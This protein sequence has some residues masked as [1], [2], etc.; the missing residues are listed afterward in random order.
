MRSLLG[1][2]VELS[3]KISVKK[4]QFRLRNFK[5]SFIFV[6]DLQKSSKS[7]AARCAAVQAK[8]NPL[9]NTHAKQSFKCRK[10][11]VKTPPITEHLAKYSLKSTLLLSKEAPKSQNLVTPA[12]PT[13]LTPTPNPARDSH[14]SPALAHQ[15]L[16]IDSGTPRKFA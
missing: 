14:R 13:T 9:E 5:K 12:H 3:T 15:S 16:K 7:F 1:A 8:C 10:T 4:P 6:T 2:E 11:H